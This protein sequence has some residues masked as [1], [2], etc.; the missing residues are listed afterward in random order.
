TVTGALAHHKSMG[1]IKSRRGGELAAEISQRVSG[2]VLDIAGHYNRY[3]RGGRQNTGIEG[4]GAV[5]RGQAD[6]RGKRDASSQQG[7][8][9]VVY[10]SLAQGLGEGQHNRGILANTGS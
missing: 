1:D 10:R 2:D 3:N 4:Y 7:K 8:G 6:L 9:I 5:I